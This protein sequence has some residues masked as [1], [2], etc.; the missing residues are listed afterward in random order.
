MPQLED[1]MGDIPADILNDEV[2]AEAP[3]DDGNDDDDA[4]GVDDGTDT[5]VD[6]DGTD[7]DAG[8]D[9][10]SDEDDD[11]AA[12]G[13]DDD[14]N[15]DYVTTAEDDEEPAPATPDDKPN[16][17]PPTATDENSYILQGLNKIAVRIIVPGDK[18][19]ETAEKT[20]EVYGYGDLP[21][22]YLGFAS[23]YEEGVFSQSVIAQEGKAEKL[24]QQFRNNQQQQDLNQYTRKENSAIAEDLTDLRTEGLFPKFKGV[25]GSKEFNESDGAKEFDRV[26]AYMNDQN[27][28]YGKAANSGKAF[29]HIG[30]REA[31]IMLNGPNLKASEQAE[32]RNRKQIASRLKGGGGTKS[33]QRNVSSKPVQNITDLEGEFASFIGGDKS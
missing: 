2:P 17:T 19:G 31:F 7:D 28:K 23:K 29:R 15:D 4:D 16:V 8:D 26:V 32:Q 11:A 6:D 33:G 27:Q 3:V 1:L 30:F 25:P 20:V 9:A 21:R 18:D 14:G 5:G 12:T 24:Q 22:N 13:D 10:G